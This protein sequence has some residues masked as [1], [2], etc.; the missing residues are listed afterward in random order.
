MKRSEIEN[1]I[2]KYNIKDNGNE[3]LTASFP[4]GRKPS[5]SE[6][7]TLKAAKAETLAYFAGIKAEKENRERK[8]AAI[9]G[10]KEIENAR[11][12]WEEYHYRFNKMMDDEFND[13]ANPPRKPKSDINELRVKYPKAAAYLKA[14]G[15]MQSSNVDKYSAGKKALE[16]IINGENYE[17]VIAEMES[18]WSKAA[19][20]AA[21]N[22]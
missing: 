8:I 3:T 10:I 4:K 13:G 7:E 2:Y 11:S 19:T 15:F 18:E 16:R 5:A 20:E 12:E 22:N 21:W 9:E 17:I 1:L 14:Q 6:I